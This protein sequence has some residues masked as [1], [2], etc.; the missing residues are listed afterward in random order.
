[1]EA[2]SS[3]SKPNGHALSSGSSDAAGAA[4]QFLLVLGT[5]NN[6]LI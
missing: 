1:M 6:A 4:L 2:A 5:S 3:T